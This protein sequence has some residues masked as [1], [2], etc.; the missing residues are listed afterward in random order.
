MYLYKNVYLTEC[1]KVKNINT[2]TA[3]VN[4]KKIALN[5]KEALDKAKLDK[6]NDILKP[7]GYRIKIW[8]AYRPKQVQ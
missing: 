3:S 2:N 1:N 8:D 6:A 7:L 5:E 4:E